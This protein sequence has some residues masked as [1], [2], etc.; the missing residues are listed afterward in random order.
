[1]AKPEVKITKI[2]SQQTNSEVSY[3]C[4]E[5]L[6][7]E[8]DVL[9]KQLNWPLDDLIA[10]LVRTEVDSFSITRDHPYLYFYARKTGGEISIKLD[11][12]AR[13]VEFRIKPPKPKTKRK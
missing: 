12:D 2:V 11:T 9:A 6:L 1:M 10:A 5:D 13:K 3:A 4:E 8:M 7:N